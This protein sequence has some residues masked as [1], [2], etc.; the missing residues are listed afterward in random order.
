MNLSI[1]QQLLFQLET[2]QVKSLLVAGTGLPEEVSAWANKNLCAITFIDTSS[3]LDSL[4]RFDF[5][6]I[7]DYIETLDKKQATQRLAKFR[8]AHSS[9]IWVEVKKNSSLSFN[10]FIGL[11]FKRLNIHNENELS[12]EG[13]SYFGFDLASYNRKRSWN[14]PK[15]WANPENWNKNRW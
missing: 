9:K 8:N 3:Y 6:V 2:Y 5:I 12:K 7:S 14:S 1:T 15:Y 11:G 13:V 4:G 10:E